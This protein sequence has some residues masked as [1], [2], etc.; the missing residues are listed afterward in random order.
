MFVKESCFSA[1]F[2]HEKTLQKIAIIA[3]CEVVTVKTDDGQHFT[4]TIEK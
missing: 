3:P 1:V 4:Y 2:F